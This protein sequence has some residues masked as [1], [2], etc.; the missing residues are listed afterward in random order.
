MVEYAVH[1]W[2]G[3]HASDENGRGGAW[4]VTLRELLLHLDEEGDLFV[5]PGRPEILEAIR[6]L[7]SASWW[8]TARSSGPPSRQRLTR[9][10]RARA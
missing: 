3:M 2:W 1:G 5:Q 10:R 4:W 6:R 9:A 8:T 7:L